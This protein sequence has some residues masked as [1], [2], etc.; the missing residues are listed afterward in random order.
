VRQAGLAL[1]VDLCRPSPVVRADAA[2][3]AHVVFN[4]VGNARTACLGKPGARIRVATR[5]DGAWAEVV[6]QDEGKGIAPEHL[7]RL[8]EPFFTTKE[9]WSNVGLGLSEAWR[10]VSEHGGTI[11]VASRPGEGSTFTVRL[12]LAPAR[13]V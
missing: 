1:E 2:Q 13:A 11:S 7:P 6:V 4:L 5:A 12:P 9:L 10:I 3:L 8:F